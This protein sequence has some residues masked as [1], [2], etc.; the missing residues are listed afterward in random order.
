VQ[1]RLQYFPKYPLKVTGVRAL[2]VIIFLRSGVAARSMGRRSLLAAEEERSATGK[3]P[4]RCASRPRGRRRRY[5]RWDLQILG[6]TSRSPGEAVCIVERASRPFGE[7]VC[8][9]DPRLQVAGE[10]VRVGN[11][12]L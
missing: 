3:A 8:V 7:A 11:P 10:V 6:H 12:C 9:G 2:H 5:H 1:T 4:Q